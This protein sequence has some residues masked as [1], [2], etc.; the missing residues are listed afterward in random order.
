[1]FCEQ[2]NNLD[3][4][5]KGTNSNTSPG[6]RISLS[7]IGN[8]FKFPS[9]SFEKSSST[10]VVTPPQQPVYSAKEPRVDKKDPLNF[11]N[12]PK[13]KETPIQTKQPPKEQVPFYSIFKIVFFCL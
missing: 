6:L 3:F 11:S 10:P 2:L 8:M 7:S 4:L 5:F 1:M 12:T 13:K 9:I